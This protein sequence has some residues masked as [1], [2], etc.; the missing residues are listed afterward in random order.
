MARFV[1]FPSKNRDCSGTPN[2]YNVSEKYWRYTSNLYC[3]TP[4]IC[5]AVP[6]W[7]LSSGERETP[8]CTSNLY[9]STPPI[10]T[11]ARLPF[12]PVILLRKYQGSGVPEGSPKKQAY[13]LSLKTSRHSS[14]QEKKFV[15]CIS[16]WE[17]SRL[18]SLKAM[19]TERNSFGTLC[20]RLEKLFRPVV[21]AK[22]LARTGKPYLPPKCSVALSSSAKRK[23]PRR[24]K[25]VY[26]FFSRC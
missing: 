25:L 24:S 23:V 21:D 20:W 22:P 1:D 15:T 19:D 8:Q 11:A 13:K 2:P 9:C 6:R 5:N 16:L 3:S 26:G 4:P 18:I 14:L 7:L 12:V 17:N 10:C